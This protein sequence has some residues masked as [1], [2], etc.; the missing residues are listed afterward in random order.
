MFA[1]CRIFSLDGN[2]RRQSIFLFLTRIISKH[3]HPSL[4]F[5][6]KHAIVILFGLC[7]MV[8]AALIFK[9]VCGVILDQLHQHPAHNHIAL[10]LRHNTTEQIADQFA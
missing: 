10:H 1:L 9:Q 8:I 6:P 7:W 5:I 2:T 3:I 4:F